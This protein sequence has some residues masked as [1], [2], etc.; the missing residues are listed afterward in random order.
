MF[1]REPNVL[2]APSIDMNKIDVLLVGSLPV[3]VQR[4]SI[5]MISVDEWLRG[6][7]DVISALRHAVRQP[8]WHHMERSQTQK[9]RAAAPCVGTQRNRIPYRPLTVW[10]SL[11]GV[12]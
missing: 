4:S 8:N 12:G 3:G 9:R 7:F 2:L 5:I 6:P 1:I 10:L 11:L